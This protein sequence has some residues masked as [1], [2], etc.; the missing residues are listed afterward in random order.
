MSQ[1]VV[2]EEKLDFKKILPVFVIVLIDLLGL[3]VIIPIMPY[4][5]ASYGADAFVIGLLGAAYPLMQFFGSPILG[6]I[7]DRVGRRPVL[8]LSQVGTFIG[9][10]IMGLANS[11]FVLFVARIIDGI[12][13]ANIATAQ[14]VI[15]DST[16]EKTRTQGLGLIGA[17]FGLGFIVGPI[18][19]FIALA[20]SGDNY[21]LVAF[22]AAGFSLLSIGLTYFWLEETHP[23]ENR[24][25]GETQVRVGLG[26]MFAALRRPGVGFLLI[27]MF[28]YQFAFYGYEHLLALFTLDRLGMNASSNA[29]LFVFAGIIIVAVQG[30]YVG[31]W[32][33]RFGDRWLMLFGLIVLA[34]GLIL[35]AATPQQPVPWY[36]ESAMLEEL[37]TDVT[38]DGISLTLPD[39]STKSWWGLAWLLVATIPA[40]IGGG[41]LMP[42]INSVLSKQVSASEV[43]GIL[44]LSAGF[45][46]LANAITPMALGALFKF[47]GSSVPFLVGG[48]ILL[49][50]YVF[51]K[52]NLPQ[53]EKSEVA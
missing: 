9:F 46:S 30:Y 35:T 6:R 21:S 22:I 10:I 33:K 15:T 36:F 17:A 1:S 41:I 24:G 5:A 29:G 32:S 52:M 7:S 20:V 19:A 27:L 42:T 34:T 2:E 48:A 50:L 37:E 14:A 45:Y 28:A 16:T 3:T 12:S 38:Q 11:L 23:V 40:S 8:L 31:K 53:K 43:G 44:G 13:G 47:F 4:Y 18:I 49:V 26:A 25:K 39:E 51:V